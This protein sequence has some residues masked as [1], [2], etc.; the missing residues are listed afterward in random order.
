MSFDI[1]TPERKCGISLCRRP[2]SNQDAETEAAYLC[3]FHYMAYLKLDGCE[4][5]GSVKYMRIIKE[6]LRQQSQELREWKRDFWDK[7]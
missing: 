2:V 6:I 3:D 4:L 1:W 7:T 5:Q